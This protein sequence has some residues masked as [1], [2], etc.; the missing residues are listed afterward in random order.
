M[1]VDAI[2]RRHGFRAFRRKF[3]GEL[4]EGGIDGVRVLALKPMTY[5]NESGR[6]VGAAARFYK[7]AADRVIVLQD[8][9]DLP[10]GKCR[11][12][13][14]GG[15]GGHNGIRSIDS[16]IGPDFWRVRLGIGHPG[17][18]GRVRGHVL[19]DFGQADRLW[20]APFLDAIVAAAPLLIAGKP[21]KFMSR[22]ALDMA[23]A[24]SPTPAAD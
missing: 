19:Q 11:V 16:H 3:D 5:M 10:P 23:S 2:A 1:A 20:L 7:L 13:K 12:K 15:A 24:P 22:V 14:G 18:K 21:D 4:G 6:S 8:E 9:L 17:D